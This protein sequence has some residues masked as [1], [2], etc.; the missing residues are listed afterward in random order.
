MIGNEKSMSIREVIAEPDEFLGNIT[1]N[2]A[3]QA[4]LRRS[5]IELQMYLFC[6]SRYTILKLKLKIVREGAD[7]SMTKQLVRVLI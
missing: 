6:N 3:A 2:L 5:L 7:R 1:V 4:Q